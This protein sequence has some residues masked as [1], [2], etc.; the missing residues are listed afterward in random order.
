MTLN[1]PDTPTPDGEQPIAPA[2]N[3][4]PPVPP[5]LTTTPTPAPAQPTPPATPTESAEPDRDYAAEIAKLR[6]ESAKRRTDN[7][8]LKSELD[9]MKEKAEKYDA[10]QTETQTEAEKLKAQVAQLENEKR[11]AKLEAEQARQ[12]ATFIRVASKAQMDPELAALIDIAKIDLSNEDSA[13][14]LLKKWSKASV[15]GGGPSNPERVAEST[16]LSEDE[17]RA[18]YFSPA[19][20]G[21]QK[22]FG[23]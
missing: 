19:G 17:L 6:K 15:T 8:A 2:A 4:P 1:N 10:L 22:M 18:R 23:G 3:I 11:Q 13:V 20:R 9:A 14:K 21:I 16:K 7:K 5:P 12:E